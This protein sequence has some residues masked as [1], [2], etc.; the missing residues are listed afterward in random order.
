[1]EVGPASTD[2]L[3]DSTL[4]QESSVPQPWDGPMVQAFQSVMEKQAATIMH[5]VEEQ[6]RKTLRA[7]GV[8]RAG[9]DNRTKSGS[10][11]ASYSGGCHGR[12]RGSDVRERYGGQGPD[13][14]CRSIRRVVTRTW[15]VSSIRSI[16]CGVSTSGRTTR[17]RILCS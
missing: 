4:N 15:I 13:L 8:L 16:S 6:V 9:G 2:A 7:A 12:R 10:S 17:G 5:E 1:M 14:L 11:G 3:I